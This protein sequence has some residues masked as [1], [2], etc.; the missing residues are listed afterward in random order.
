MGTLASTSSSCP[1]AAGRAGFLQGATAAVLL[2]GSAGALAQGLDVALPGE[3][4]LG[5]FD[6]GAQPYGLFAIMTGVGGRPVTLIEA[7]GSVDGPWLPV[8]L[9]YQVNDPSASLPF[10]FPHFPRMDWTLWFVPL[11][12][13]GPWFPR[14][15]RGILSAE[16]SILSLIDEAAL[17]QNFPEGPAFL[18]VSDVTYTLD[19]L[20]H[21]APGTSPNDFFP[22]ATV[23]AR[24]DF[25]T[26][27]RSGSLDAWQSTPIRMLSDH[28]SPELFV[29]TWFVLAAASSPRSH[30][31][32]DAL[33]LDIPEVLALLRAAGANRESSDGRP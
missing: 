6:V 20:G 14:F 26:T 3:S 31:G 5:V 13:A 7:A 29:W 18:R 28:L 30:R 27:S 8:P 33:G 11:G 9:R 24:S 12:E 16:P 23:L 15:L 25:V 19:N 32:R 4:L 2:A 22:D 17:R 21:W 1:S 10:C